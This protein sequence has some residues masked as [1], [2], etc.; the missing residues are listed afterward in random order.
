MAEKYRTYNS[1]PNFKI[2]LESIYEYHKE[3]FQAQKDE[4]NHPNK[5]FVEKY[6]NENYINNYLNGI[7][8]PKEIRE[9]IDNLFELFKYS[10]IYF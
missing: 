2:E 4:Y 7:E 10:L 8:I 9:K 1:I 5:I 3:F 6:D